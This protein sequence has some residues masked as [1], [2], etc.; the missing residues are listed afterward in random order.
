MEGLFEKGHVMDHVNIEELTTEL[1]KTFFFSYGQLL[2]EKYHINIT[3]LFFYLKT[4]FIRHLYERVPKK[5]G[6]FQPI[7]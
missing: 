7:A 2:A 1:M 3:A 6:T 5:D 4:N